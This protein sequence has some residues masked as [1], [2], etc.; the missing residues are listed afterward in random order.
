MSSR[1]QWA[2]GLTGFFLL[3]LVLT[4]QTYTF[5]DYLDGLGNLNVDCLLQDRA[6]F[7]WVG[8]ESGLYRYDGSRFLPF[9]RR[10]GLPGLWIRAL[11]EDSSGRL[12]AA[13]TDGLAYRSPSGKFKTVKFEG[14]DIQS[15]VNSTL[16]SAPDGSVYSAN[17][18]GLLVIRTPDGGRT[19]E[20]DQV[21]PQEFLRTF[22]PHGI[23]SV[24]A[25]AK[26]VIFGCGTGVCRLADNS[27]TV[28]GKANALPADKW[29]SLLIRKNG[30]VWVRGA[31]H[32]AVLAPGQLRFQV[33][34]LPATVNDQIYSP[35][36]EDSHGNVLAGLNSAMARYTG[37]EWAIFAQ[38]SGFGEGNVTSMLEDREGSMWF[39]LSGH[40]LRKWLGYPHW[41]HWTKSQGLASN[42][43]WAMLRDRAGRLWVGDEQGIDTQIPGEQQF[44]RWRP[45]TGVD[46]Q[47]VRS[48]AESKDGSIWAGSAS[49]HLI[50]ISTD[51]VHARQTTFDPIS[52]VLV[53]SADRVWLATAGGLFM[54]E[55]STNIRQFHLVR[56][57]VLGV[58]NFPDV[59][60]DS[61]GDIWAI[62]DRQ[63]FRMDRSG[64]VDIDISPANL[65]RHLADVLVDHEGGVWVDGIGSGAARLRISRNKVAA[66]ARP[67]LASN[68][69]L[70]I[71]MDRRGRVWLGQDSG[72]EVF[73]GP[74]R[75][76]FTLD[77]GLI[78]NDC[79]AKAFWSDSDGSVWIGTSGGLSHASALD[80]ALTPP[81]APLITNADFGAR[82]LLLGPQKIPWADNSLNI[83]LASLS[84]RNEQAIRFRYRLVGLEPEWVETASREIRFPRLSP[85]AYRFEAAAIDADTGKT[86][87]PASLVFEIEP[88]WWSSATFICISIAVIVLLMFA[89]GRWRVKL[90]MLRQRELER[91][92]AERTEQLDR[93]LM[94]EESLKAE[95]ERANHAKSEFLAM[96]S[97]EIRTPMNGV[98]GMTGLLL[99]TALD[100]EQQE[101]VSAIRDSGAALVSIINEILDF[102]KIEAGKLTLEATDFH[103]HSVV[104][105]AAN[106]V[107][108]TV[109]HKGLALVTEI[110]PKIPE[111][112]NGDPVRLRQILLN[113][114]SNA[115]KFTETGGI[116][117]SISAIAEGMGACDSGTVK[118]RFAVSDTGIGICPEAQAR[119]FRPFSQAEDCTTRKYGGTG[120]GLAISKKLAE[121]MGGEIGAEST[122]GRGSIFWFTA[123]LAQT[124]AQE[125]I[126]RPP[127]VTPASRISLKGTILIAEDNPINQKVALR[128]LSHLGYRADVV[129]DGVEAI[130]RLQEQTYDVI[131][132]DCQMPKM[133]GFEATRAI[134]Q[135]ESATVRTPIIAVTANA[136]TGERERCLAAGMDDYLPKPVSRDALNAAIQRWLA[137]AEQSEDSALLTA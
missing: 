12:W 88:P 93:K 68:E 29:T 45:P 74:S 94:E 18:F 23:R 15:G 52:R 69:I 86:S 122:P 1:R 3:P 21:L 79:D 110:D 24:A 37:G 96:M 125:Q 116:T 100:T 105:D 32:A 70:F 20:C 90:M 91:L 57:S 114:L 130:Q 36:A 16:S 113:F 39:G 27:V 2:A 75:R 8:T 28:W 98:I 54:S 132:M 80:R 72:V 63:L 104:K 14:H 127:D 111:F 9:G 38:K 76:R 126:T 117:I 30:E 103:L 19:W 118:L 5:R 53:D 136:V 92:V 73:A 106:L 134:R 65:G 7:I 89:L 83:G 58:Q 42:E 137:A 85:H 120:L 109:H 115:V 40:G 47:A 50:Q 31:K 133:D 108:E 51:R 77:N 13:T 34:D 135:M 95:A 112:L 124:D 78:W 35:L 33:R 64:W 121:L 4:A 41:E 129:N 59:A 62:S 71:G 107:A 56:D 10:D 66:V 6:G 131:L 84:F 49:G 46:A 25:D 43:V 48:L 61:H 55:P 99:D 119:L 60:Q 11:H 97:H 22:G 101:F 82:S 26:S 81:P 17:Q 128:L 67:A 123:V 44:R 87:S 102:S